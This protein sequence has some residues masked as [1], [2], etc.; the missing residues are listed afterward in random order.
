MPPKA[1]RGAARG[2]GRGRGKA[3]APPPVEQ[4]STS[5]PSTHDNM[6]ID[7]Q[8]TMAPSSPFEA[9]VPK[10]TTPQND[11]L[12]DA[13]PSPNSS[14][15]TVW[16]ETPAPTPI[17]PSALRPEPPP[18]LPP[19]RGGIASRGSRVKA[20][21]SRFKPKNIRRD[22]KELEDLRKKEQARLAAIASE[23][24]GREALKSRGAMGRGWGMRGR[25]DAMGRG[26]GRGKAGT[27]SGIFGVMPEALQKNPEFLAPKASGS[28][29]VGSSRSGGGS[30]SGGPKTVKVDGITVSRGDYTSSAKGRSSDFLPD[31]QYPDEDLDAP[32]VD[33]ELINLV[34][35]ESDDDPIFTGS[36]KVSKGRSKS[37]NK[38][39][40]KP[41]RLHREEHKERVTLVNTDPAIKIQSD[42]EEEFPT[43]DELQSSRTPAKSKKFKGTFEEYEATETRIKAEPGLELTFH[44]TQ[45]SPAA[46]PESN[47]QVKDRTSSPESKRKTKEQLANAV[48]L[49]GPEDDVAAKAKRDRKARTS[50]KKKDK[51]PVI[52]TEEDRAEYERHLEDVAILANELGGLQGNLGAQSQDVEGDVAMDGVSQSPDKKEG[53]LYL[54]QFPPV[55]PEL[56]NP[57]HPKPKTKAEIKAETENEKAE[58][59]AQMGGMSAKAKGKMKEQAERVGDATVIKVEEEVV[60]GPDGKPKKEDEKRKRDEVVHEEGW[61]GKLVVRESGKVELCWGGTNLLVGRGVDAGFLTTGVMVDMVERGPPSGGAPVGKALSMG[62]VMG[63]FVV[64]PDWEKMV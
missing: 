15:A 62:Q 37:T 63:K 40:L 11:F 14:P 26:A 55:L 22:A 52:Q 31:P 10:I 28:G 50:S 38:G 42:S 6:E 17:R 13:D 12:N 30:G 9:P 51:K 41:V 34:S 24:A 54:F 39:G 44:G 48:D 59:D 23:E 35:D 19:T 43:V 36:R 33:I 1:A 18:I 53:R 29:G 56:Y 49:D 8:S 27:A 61:I 3:S 45:P 7:S 46:S 60:L 57:K 25:G 4:P 2:R 58:K 32:R 5:Q 16:T 21:E 20:T 47:R 64:T